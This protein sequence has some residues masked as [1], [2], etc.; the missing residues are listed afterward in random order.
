[1]FISLGKAIKKRTPSAT[2]IATPVTSTDDKLNEIDTVDYDQ[3]S[4]LRLRTNP[5]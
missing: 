1:M 2:H 3:P 4:D 5:K